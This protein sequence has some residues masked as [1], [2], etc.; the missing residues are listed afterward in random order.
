MAQSTDMDVQRSL[1]D[2]YKRLGRAA[3]GGLV[4]VLVAKHREA[5]SDNA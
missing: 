3:D 5:I 1:A 4:V 2:S